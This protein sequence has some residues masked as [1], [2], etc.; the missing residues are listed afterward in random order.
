M[1][2]SLSSR[3]FDPRPVAARVY[4][5]LYGIYRELHDTFGAVPG[6]RADL[7]TLMKRLLDLRE[8]VGGE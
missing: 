6:A 8:R 4:D 7:A 5:D 3:R 2:S 1:P